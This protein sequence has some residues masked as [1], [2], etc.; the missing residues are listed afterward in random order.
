MIQLDPSRISW[1]YSA[2]SCAPLPEILRSPQFLSFNS[3]HLLL[4]ASADD[5]ERILRSVSVQTNVIKG[6]LTLNARQTET[7]IVL[8][9]ASSTFSHGLTPDMS[10]KYIQQ[11]HLDSQSAIQLVLD[12]V[13]SAIAKF[14]EVFVCV[15]SKTACTITRK[16]GDNVVSV[17]IGRGRYKILSNHV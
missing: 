9:F 16:A 7:L 3:H 10:V 15:Y 17:N 5:L 8:G 6:V 1:A 4:I 11:T 14:D 13:G 2:M 12:R